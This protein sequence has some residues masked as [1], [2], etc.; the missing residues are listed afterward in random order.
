MHKYKIG[1]TSYEESSFVELEHET[2]FTKDEIT[3]MIGEAVVDKIRNRDANDYL[4]N[5]G[6]FED[7]VIDYLKD[8]KGFKEIIYDVEW[9]ISGWASLFDKTDRNSDDLPDE[10][11]KIVDMVN[12]AGFDRKYD[13]CL[14]YDDI[15]N[16]SERKC[17]LCGGDWEDDEGQIIVDDEAYIF[18][19][20]CYDK[21]NDGDESKVFENVR[22]TIREK[23]NE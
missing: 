12:K 17:V 8:I 5:Y 4:H 19:T 21:H 11:I 10:N 15:Y 16:M 9:T 6:N 14:R 7:D 22:I 1:Y 20:K 13:D 23:V 2:L 18:C 3:K